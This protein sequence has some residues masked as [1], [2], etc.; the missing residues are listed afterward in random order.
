MCK[1]AFYNPSLSVIVLQKNESNDSFDVLP[2]LLHFAVV[3][4][5]LPVVEMLLQ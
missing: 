2:K 3:I 4:L 1:L 5:T